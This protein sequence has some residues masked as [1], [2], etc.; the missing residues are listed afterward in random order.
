MI[1]TWQIAPH[2][3]NHLLLHKQNKQINEVQDDGL[4]VSSVAFIIYVWVLVDRAADPIHKEVEVV[5]MV[6]LRQTGCLAHRHQ[7]AHQPTHAVLPAV[8]RS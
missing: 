6:M 1:M 7:W 4:Q 5:I 2:T 8:V 3:A